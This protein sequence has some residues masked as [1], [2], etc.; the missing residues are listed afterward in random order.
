MAF[1]PQDVLGKINNMSYLADDYNDDFPDDIPMES[2]ESD[3]P[4]TEELNQLQEEM[5]RQGNATIPKKKVVYLK[6]IAREIL[7]KANDSTLSNEEK[8]ANEE[9]FKNK[10][11]NPMHYIQYRIRKETNFD[12]FDIPELPATCKCSTCG[13]E[14]IPTDM[15][16]QNAYHSINGDIPLYCLVAR[17][18]FAEKCTCGNYLAVNCNEETVAKWLTN[19]NVW[20][21]L[22]FEDCF[23]TN[24]LFGASAPI[25]TPPV[26]VVNVDLTG[27]ENND[28]ERLSK[29]NE[30]IS[31][32]CKST[33]TEYENNTY[34]NEVKSLKTSAITTVAKEYSVLNFARMNNIEKKVSVALLKCIMATLPADFTETQKN[35]LV[36][37]VA[38]TTSA[39]T[40]TELM[41]LSIL[42]ADEVKELSSSHEKVL[43]DKLQ[44]MI[45]EKM[46]LSKNC[47]WGKVK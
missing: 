4:T 21:Q 25:E 44:I 12:L 39:E 47:I 38:R 46:I 31:D 43:Y 8:K 5:N 45:K 9:E 19:N 11:S 10:Y 3:G 15:I 26:E 36:T 6:D 30:E 27:Q 14:Y 7:Q 23:S 24:E 17:Y 1:M 18:D 37:I 41:G 42:S 35:N 28:L 40:E 33:V 13:K 2:S 20:K 32:F 29:L 22:S 16:P 34:F